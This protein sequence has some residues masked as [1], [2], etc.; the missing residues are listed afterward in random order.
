MKIHSKIF[1]TII[2]F[3]F[4]IVIALIYYQKFSELKFLQDD[5][6]T[7]LRYANNFLN[8]K[9]L[10]FNPD[11]K[12]EGFTNFLWV[13]LLST[14]KLIGNIFNISIHL[15][16]LTQTLSIIFGFT[17]L[18]SVF[19]LSYKI[20]INQKY[21]S[22][23]IYSFSFVIVFMILNSTP[24]LYWSVSG[25]ETSLFATLTLISIYLFIENFY[26][27]KIALFLIVSFA[28]SLLRPEGIIFF[29]ILVLI[30][31][32]INYIKRKKIKLC[33]RI[34]D[35]ID[36]FINKII[37]LFV[38][39]MSFFILFRLLYYGYPLP[40]T[41]YAKTEFNYEFITRGFNYFMEFFQ[42][43]LFYG[44]I[45]LPILVLLIKK[46]Y[47][48][49]SLT[50]ILFSLI[51]ILLIIII[52]GDVLPMGR[53]FLPI[54][55]LVYI[56]FIVSTNKIVQIYF[57]KDSVQ[58]FYS[59][60]LITLL[61]FSIIYYKEQK[62]KMLDKRAYEIGLVRKMK[63]YAEWISKKNQGKNV[64]V[65]LSTIGAFS[66]YS[67][68]IVI[69]LVG[70]TDE[71]IAHHP[72]EV[73]GIKDELPLLWK[74][75]HY[76][77]DYVLNRKPDYIIFPAGVKPSAFAECA[78]FV[79]KKFYKNYYTQ[80]FYDEGFGQLLPVFTRID[81]IRKDSLTCNISFL[82]NYINANN[83]LISSIK[84]GNRNLL[85]NILEETDYV[86]KVCPNRS[87]EMNSI[88][89][90]AFYHLG[91]YLIAKK[92][93]EI[94]ME[95]DESNS[96]AK[97]YLLNTNLKLG[98]IDNAVQLIGPLLKYSPDVF[99]NNFYYETTNLVRK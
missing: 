91:N 64:V 28:N 53:F 23:F 47:E 73:E 2:K 58:Y 55:P 34:K 60:M 44:L 83:L 68:A 40:N 29:F 54:I 49:E 65:A 20:F 99:G 22:F 92:Y 18:V 95:L 86:I 57:R 62:P 11:E 76:N 7:S 63:I 27:P 82:K 56:L 5:A 10:V 88:K 33:N 31:I 77:A 43:Q 85:K 78:V 24:F 6:F 84:S 51:N 75:K 59:L 4:W 96:I 81:M 74:E 93:F 21:S 19:L 35:S 90:M 89:G 87:S 50:L 80:L 45:L 14:I 13:I 12:V 1:P 67:N 98:A 36:P 72:K 71:F 70:L 8:G 97:F 61:L 9:G 48:K 38:T 69:D 3:L 66:Y 52:G 16:E 46:N 42:D 26:S 41:Y 32:A 79:N 37:P 39:I 25:M 94:A 30:R 17:F 15:E